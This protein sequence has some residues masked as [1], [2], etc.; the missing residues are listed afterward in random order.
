MAPVLQIEEARER[1]ERMLGRISD[2]SG[3]DAASALRMAGRRAAALGAG[4]APCWPAWSWP[5]TARWRFSQMAPFEEIYV[6]DRAGRQA[7]QV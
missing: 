3:L 6:R 5:A 4:L 2:W 1:L 7:A